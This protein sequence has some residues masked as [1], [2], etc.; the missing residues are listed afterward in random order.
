MKS[1]KIA[2]TGANG[3]IG[4]HLTEYFRNCGY[5]V[6]KMVRNPS[7]EE[8]YYDLSN[9]NL[10]FEYLSNIDT[11]IHCAS[12]I[13]QKNL[14][15]Q[16]LIEINAL[17]TKC[18]FENALKQGVKSFINLS[19]GGV[20]GTDYMDWIDESYPCNPINAY[21]K[22]KLLSEMYCPQNKEMRVIH[23]RL[24]FPYGSNQK[25]RLIPNIIESVKTQ[26]TININENG[27]PIINPVHI[28]DVIQYLDWA[29]HS[30]A[31]GIY[32]L[33]GDQGFSI[34]EIAEIVSEI[35]HVELLT[36]SNH[37]IVSNLLGSNLKIK[38]ASNLSNKTDFREGLYSIIND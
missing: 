16:D 29:V 3:F 33:S 8:I 12:I 25:G 20:Y 23:M 18:L 13:D 35:S 24:F 10:S 14:T 34:R 37:K 26:K 11:L 31:Q 9:H 28:N 1:T 36:E 4:S 17:G 19:T 15:D 30:N 38:R 22:S 2:I 5:E 32:N 7:N 27:A 6:I 21:G